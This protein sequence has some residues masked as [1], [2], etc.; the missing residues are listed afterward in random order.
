MF[1]QVFLTRELAC[2]LPLELSHIREAQS[3]QSN[4]FQGSIA[5]PYTARLLFLVHR[6]LPSPREEPRGFSITHFPSPFFYPIPLL[7]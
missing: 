7:M 5:L 6:V 4:A 3:Q 1:S 2:L